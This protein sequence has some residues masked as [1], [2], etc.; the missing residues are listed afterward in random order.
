MI[1]IETEIYIECS[2]RSPINTTIPVA[3][4]GLQSNRSKTLESV[5]K[6]ELEG[7]IPKLVCS[8][9]GDYRD[10]TYIK[11]GWKIVGKKGSNKI[12]NKEAKPYAK[13]VRITIEFPD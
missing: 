8:S 5:I 10:G 7:E 13:K 12:T 1:T 11:D 9:I 3:E 6:E 2:H 4:K